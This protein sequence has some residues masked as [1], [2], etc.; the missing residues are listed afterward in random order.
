MDDVIGKNGLMKKLLKDVMKQL[1]EAEMDEH[2]G[3]DKYERTDNESEKNY[4]IYIF[5][6]IIVR[7]N[8]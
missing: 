2:L 4:W 1:L 6:N 5:K 7:K 8:Y 3:W